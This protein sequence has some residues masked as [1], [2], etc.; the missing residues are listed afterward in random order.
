MPVKYRDEDAQRWL[1]FHGTE[2]ADGIR[3]EC[4]CSKLKN[5]KCS[6]YDIR[7]EVCRVFE[8]GSPMCRES[9]Q[10]RRPFKAAEIFKLIEDQ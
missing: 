10:R 4:K 1:L 2:T 3:L 6:I 7:P 5:G 9:V 8:V